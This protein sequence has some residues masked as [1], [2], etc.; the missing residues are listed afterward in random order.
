MVDV[1][2]AKKK[3]GTNVWQYYYNDTD[4]QKWL[5]KSEGEGTY[6]LVSKCNLLYMTAQE[7]VSSSN[8]NICVCD[9]STDDSQKFKFIKSY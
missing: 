5:I 3:F 7:N 9:K 2:H 6:S 1:Y 4:A 8:I